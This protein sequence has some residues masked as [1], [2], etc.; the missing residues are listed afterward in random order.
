MTY[1]PS[2]NCSLAKEKQA[3]FYPDLD[4]T[5]DLSEEGVADSEEQKVEG[6]IRLSRQKR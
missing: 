5:E 1:F 6:N 3:L 4:Y 2:D